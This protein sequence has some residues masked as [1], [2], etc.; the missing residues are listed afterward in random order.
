MAYLKRNIKYLNGK[1]YLYS[2]R[3]EGNIIGVKYSITLKG[4]T[5][6][7]KA[8]QFCLKAKEIEERAKLYPTDRVWID[9]MH[10]ALAR[11]DL[12]PNYNDTIP[13]IKSAWK[14]LVDEK[15]MHKQVK[16]GN[17]TKS[18]E[19]AQDILIEVLGNIPV[20]QISKVHKPK[21]INALGNRGWSDN[22]IN[23][24]VRNIML[25]LRWCLEMAYID[26]LPFKLRQISV[27]KRTKT[28]I[29]ETDFN[30]ICSVMDEVYKS[31]AIVSYHTGL[32]LRELNTNP[33]DRM[34]KGLYH[35]LSRKDNAYK[36]KVY[37][38]Q[39]TIKDIVL[40]DEF[41]S[42]YDVMVANR[43]NPNNVSKAFKRACEKVGFG[44][45]RFHDIRH[46]F[47]SNYVLK[48][49]NAYLLKLA[50]RHSSLNTT[51][52]YLND[53]KLGWKMLL[54]NVENQA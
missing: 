2:Y 20:N 12:L 36:L 8:N 16:V 33:D 38:K 30:L 6:K 18:Y 48:T 24:R 32:R 40:P 43:R 14:E 13:T 3:I 42:E 4:I 28:W 21:L 19:Y 29:Q 1:K 35:V 22:T 9:E 25:F 27:A 5:N 11:Q 49:D 54:E 47:C 37:G 45:Y 23:Q 50:M 46:T 34:Y 39:N 7:P 31:Y 17:T 51:Q 52:G 41:K 44:H 26:R 53:S 15:I 10:I